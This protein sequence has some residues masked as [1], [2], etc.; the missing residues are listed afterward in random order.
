[1]ATPCIAWG[2]SWLSSRKAI[3]PVLGDWM[4][5]V[6][7]S[8]PSVGQTETSHTECFAVSSTHLQNCLV[9]PRYMMDLARSKKETRM[10]GGRGRGEERKM[11]AKGKDIR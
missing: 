1:M 4:Y 3:K 11:G 9:D 7:M 8:L 2:S 5:Q 10:A 6:F